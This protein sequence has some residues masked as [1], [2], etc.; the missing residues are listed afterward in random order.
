MNLFGD[1]ITIWVN[2]LV[3]GKKTNLRA[4]LESLK[5]LVDVNNIELSVYTSYLIA[6]FSI[7]IPI[8]FTIWNFRV[9]IDYFLVLLIINI[10][11][12]FSLVDRIQN[13]RYCNDFLIEAYNVIQS[14]IAGSYLI[15]LDGNRKAV[16]RQLKEWQEQYRLETPFNKF[17]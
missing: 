12:V 17:S 13:I 10:I 16:F 6:V 7:F 15:C 4:Q 14:K 2:A 8:Y 5:L 3:K 1:R 9:Q 11:I